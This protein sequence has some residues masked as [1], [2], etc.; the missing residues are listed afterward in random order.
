MYHIIIREFRTVA[1]VF[2][3]TEGGKTD[4]TQ[5]PREQVRA[6]ALDLL[7]QGLPVNIDHYVSESQEAASH[8]IRLG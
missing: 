1:H 4:W 2:H 7:A 6:Q 5:A 8:A 3:I